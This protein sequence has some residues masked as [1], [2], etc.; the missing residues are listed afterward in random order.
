MMTV[1]L[2]YKMEWWCGWF[3]SP[4]YLS[5]RLTHWPVVPPTGSSS[6]QSCLSKNARDQP[7]K[8]GDNRMDVSESSWI[9]PGSVFSFDP[10]VTVSS[11]F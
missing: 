5:C 10:Y 8:Q 2:P 1:C 3:L 6:Y 9:C 11:K 7:G 4:P